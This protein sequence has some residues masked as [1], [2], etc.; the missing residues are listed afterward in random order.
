MNED[1]ALRLAAAIERLAA[2]LE[3]KDAG[4]E[5]IFALGPILP[6]HRPHVAG[7]RR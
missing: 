2:L 3:D 1:T 5:V 6:K 4:E 7:R